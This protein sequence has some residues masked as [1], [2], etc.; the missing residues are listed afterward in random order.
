[1]RKYGDLSIDL[2]IANGA[3]EAALAGRL[4]ARLASRPPIVFVG[5]DVGRPV[6]K[7]TGY[8][9]RYGM[10][11]SLDLALRVHPDTRHA[12]I[13]CGAYPSDAGTKTSFACKCP[14]R[15]EAWSSPSYADPPFER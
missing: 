7:S 6:L 2:L 8:T 4:Q 13:V 5:L 12:F 9:Y 14:R 15:R 3:D 1:M 10:K 11:E